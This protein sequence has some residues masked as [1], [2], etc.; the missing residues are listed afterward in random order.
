MS[1]KFVFKTWLQDLCQKNNW[2]HFKS[3][4]IWRELLDRGGKGILL[5]DGNA[6]QEYALTYYGIKSELT[7]NDLTKIGTENENTFQIVEEEKKK[8]LASINPFNLTIS[9]PESP[10]LYFIINELLDENI[11]S[12]DIFIRLY[13]EN[14]TENIDGILMEIQDLASP[15]L[16]NIKV[17]QD[18]A[19]AFKDCDFAIILDDL[20][21][22][23]DTNNEE[24]DLE[25]YKNPYIN[26]AKA[27]DQNAR[28]NCK[29]LISP[30]NSRNETY[31]LVNLVSKYLK[32]INPKKFLI[33][34]SM[35]DEMIAKAIVAHRLRINPAYV[36]NVI[37]MGQNFSDSFYVDLTY[38]R[39]TDFDGAV[40]AKTG[41]HWL[42]L[43]S[44]VADKQWINKDFMSLVIDRGIFVNVNFFFQS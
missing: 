44:M 25:K 35:C 39:V 26:L 38:A 22:K 11:F 23:I 9:N 18:S 24:S 20:N 43:I 40:W 16:R 13:C 33:G 3:P 21:E 37:V 28:Q 42:N 17:V 4:I 7:S 34:N 41:T 14:R 1:Y 5:G 32:R 10:A 8:V 2:K 30:F 6:F 31:A 15:Y 12:K 19:E 36:S 29:V 27:I